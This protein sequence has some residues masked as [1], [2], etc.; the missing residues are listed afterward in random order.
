MFRSTTGP[1]ANIRTIT[2]VDSTVS[3]WA[4]ICVFRLA[5]GYIADATLQKLVGWI[6]ASLRGIL[7]QHNSVDFV[8]IFH[9]C[10]NRK[11]SPAVYVNAT[12]IYSLDL[13]S[14]S[15]NGEN[16]TLSYFLFQRAH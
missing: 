14:T 5:P 15:Y 10:T 6:P 7:C 1:P 12:G 8:A 9:D 16:P 3:G 11:L 2:E 13:P 4:R